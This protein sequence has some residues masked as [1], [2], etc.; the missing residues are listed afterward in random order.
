MAFLTPSQLVNAYGA[1]YKEGNITRQ[2]LHNQIFTATDTK[3]IFLVRPTTNTR[4]DNINVTYQSVLQPFY[5][6]FSAL[7]AMDFDPNPFNLDR[8][9]INVALK[10][11]DLAATAVDF[12]VQ[13]GLY[14]KDAPI[15]AMISEYLIL[16]AKED[17]ELE[18]VFKG[19]FTLPSGPDQANG[20][21]GNAAGAR[22][23]IRKII[24]DYNNAG[25]FSQESSVIAMGTPPTDP[26][27][28]VEYIETLYYSIPE[29]FRTYI[30]A[31]NMSETLA[32]RF[33]LGMRKKY[34]VNYA[35]ATDFAKIIDTNCVIRGF[36]SHNG[37]TMIWATLEGNAIGFVK[38]P[39]NQ[40]VFAVA[41]R[42]LYEV[43]MGTDWY[44]AYNFIN[45]HWIWTNGQDLS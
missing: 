42:D 44:E 31:L 8:V 9:K 22:N 38:N 27:L 45:P 21:P 35:Q 15:I 1:Y 4:I 40:G 33:K 25:K 32:T 29:K 11:D 6:K 2:N 7:G 17:D 3:Q 23:G 19:V 24:R 37:S 39:E 5:S 16:K 26:V 12:L 13:R 43:I 34:N 36:A 28:F 30:K 18:T 14:R 10:P 41:E 20:V